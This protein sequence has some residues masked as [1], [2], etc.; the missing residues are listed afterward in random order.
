MLA[1]KHQIVV[2]RLERRQDLSVP[3]Q[4]SQAPGKSWPVRHAFSL[5]LPSG[6]FAKQSL[7]APRCWMPGSRPGMKVRVTQNEVWHDAWMV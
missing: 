6:A 3:W 5:T 2:T 4:R 1:A 7:R